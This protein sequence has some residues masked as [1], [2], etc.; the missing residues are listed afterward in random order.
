MGRFLSFGKNHENYSANFKPK[1][2]SPKSKDP[3]PLKQPELELPLPRPKPRKKEEGEK[4][5]RGFTIVDYDVDHT[6][7]CTI[8][9]L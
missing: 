6:S 2:K 3:F 9:K 5:K 7:D 1:K 4:Q 8:Y